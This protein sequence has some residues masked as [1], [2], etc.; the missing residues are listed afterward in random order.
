MSDFTTY[1]EICLYDRHLYV[2]TKLVFVIF[3]EL[4]A[5]CIVKY[6]N[7]PLHIGIYI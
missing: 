3:Y 6:I 1:I 5:Y 7:I 4:F 2:P